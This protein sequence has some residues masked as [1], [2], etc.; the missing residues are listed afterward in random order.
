[1]KQYYENWVRVRKG[2]ISGKYNE[3]D[4]FI[5]DLISFG[6]ELLYEYGTRDR[7]LSAE[8]AYMAFI[9]TCF[10][11]FFEG[12][13]ECVQ[14]GHNAINLRP[15][16]LLTIHSGIT[17]RIYFEIDEKHHDVE[18][19]RKE[20]ERLNTLLIDAK[21]KNVIRVD[22]LRINIGTNKVPGENEK[23]AIEALI[24]LIRKE[25]GQSK[26]GVFCWLLDYARWHHHTMTYFRRV[27]PDLT[28]VDNEEDAEE[29]AE[30][31]AVHELS[32]DDKD[33]IQI[34]VFDRVQMFFSSTERKKLFGNFTNGD[35]DEDEDQ[36]DAAQE[37][38]QE[39]K[40]PE[41]EDQEDAA[42]ESSQEGK[43]PE[44]GEEDEDFSG[45][46]GVATMNI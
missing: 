18:S 13:D 7:D 15:D 34:P 27:K 4:P 6:V 43:V 31:E 46:K 20:Q 10:G 28:V 25:Q 33:N 12:R 17:I 19:I 30:E 21:E 9:Q 37:T 22:V 40:V 35:I 24:K 2:L 39:G 42:Q 41:D 11:C 5:K 44:D 26:P 1:M 14:V 8:A 29:D 45:L 36:E 16:G 23:S 3:T 32:A 38:S